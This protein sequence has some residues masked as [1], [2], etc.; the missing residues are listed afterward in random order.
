MNLELSG[1]RLKHREAALAQRGA[2][3]SGVTGTKPCSDLLDQQLLSNRNK[4]G[5][6]SNRSRLGVIRKRLYKSS[7]ACMMS[8]HQHT[9]F[10]L[11]RDRAVQGSESDSQSEEG[12]MKRTKGVRRVATKPSSLNLSPCRPSLTSPSPLC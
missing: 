12:K 8:H 1:K 9:C 10:L 2:S 11:R 3:A 4:E 5:L 6:L 7:Q